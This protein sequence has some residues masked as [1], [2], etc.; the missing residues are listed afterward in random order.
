MSGAHPRSVAV[1]LPARFATAFEES[2]QTEEPD[3]CQLH[4]RRDPWRR[5]ARDP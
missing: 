2:D 5:R 4:C 1:V 3:R